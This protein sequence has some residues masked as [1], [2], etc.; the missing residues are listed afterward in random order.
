MATKI[1]LVDISTDEFKEIIRQVIKEAIP[2]NSTSS[3]EPKL[4]TSK[5]AAQLLRISLPTLWDY[6]KRGIIKATRIGNK[7]L[8]LEQGILDL[9]NQ[10]GKGGRS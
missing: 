5:E 3:S 1:L 4:L 10:T 9:F 7:V 6:R 2:Q 8:F